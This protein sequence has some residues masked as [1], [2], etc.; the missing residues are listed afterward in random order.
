MSGDLA[1]DVYRPLADRGV[2]GERP[3]DR[4]A[5]GL[6]AAD[7]LNQR[8]QMRG[9]ERVAD[10]TAFGVPAIDLHSAHQQPRRT[11]RDGDLRIEDGIEPGQQGALQILTLGSAFLHELGPSQGRFRL[12]VEVQRGPGRLGR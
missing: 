4:L 6:L 12:G 3:F 2:E 8:H 10:D 5:A 1:P 7:H 9:I 11:R